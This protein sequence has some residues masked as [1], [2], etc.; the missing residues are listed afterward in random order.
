MG[1][2]RLISC[3]LCWVASLV[4]SETLMPRLAVEGCVT[5]GCQ[6]VRERESIRVEKAAAVGR[7]CET[8]VVHTAVYRS[9]RGEESVPRRGASFQ[10]V[11]AIADCCRAQVVA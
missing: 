7:Q 10:C 6:W 4:S 5:T 2:V 9:E 3:R 11:I 1:V 8:V